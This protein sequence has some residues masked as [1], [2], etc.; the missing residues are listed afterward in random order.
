MQD[1][2]R[3]VHVAAR[4]YG[5]L[6]AALGLTPRQLGAVV[7]LEHEARSQD[8][9]EAFTVARVAQHGEKK[10]ADRLIKELSNVAK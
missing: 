8:L 5:S 10:D 4:A 7:G 1:V 2:A 3:A 9:T 6:D